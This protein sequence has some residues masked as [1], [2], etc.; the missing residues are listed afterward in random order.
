MNTKQEIINK[1]N[2]IDDPELLH[3]LDKWI[4]SMVEATTGEEFSKDEIAAVQEG[5]E[6]YK[7][8]DIVNREKANRF[9]NEWLKP[10]KN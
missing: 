10:Q 3:E 5:Y 6:Q 1:I 7:T 2:R 4:S 8:G 9:F